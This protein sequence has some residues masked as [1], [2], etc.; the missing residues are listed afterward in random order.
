MAK[1]QGVRGAD[2]SRARSAMVHREPIHEQILPHIRQDIVLGRWKPGDRLLE[3]DLCEEFGVSRT[4]LRDVLKIL[5]MEGLV[6][7]VPHVGAVVTELDSPD[8]M[9]KFEVLAGLEQTA[10]R[11]VAQ[12]RPRDVLARICDL[13]AAMGEAAAA[14]RVKEYYRLNDDFHRA[15]VL[16]AHNATLALIHETVMWHV[17]RARHY[18]NEYEPLREG[19]VEHHSDIVNSI[20]RG[21]CEAAGIAMREHMEEVMR[22]VIGI[23]APKPRGRAPARAPAKQPAAGEAKG[24]ARAPAPATRRARQAGKAVAKSSS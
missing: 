9:E 7:L 4:P 6:R 5:E 24:A 13:N 15:I 21:D 3:P 17:Y 18:V 8:L 2:G 1:T 19:A 10:A 22:T 20:L 12:L 16:G 23:A 14:N 11:K